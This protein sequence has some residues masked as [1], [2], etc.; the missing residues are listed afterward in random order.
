VTDGAEAYPEESLNPY[1][2]IMKRFVLLTLSC[3]VFLS[4]ISAQDGPDGSDVLLNPGKGYITI[5][6]FTGGF[7]LGDTDVP[8]AKGFFGFTTIHGCQLNKSIVVAGG[9][10]VNFYN[11]GTLF[12]LF[13]DLRYRA[14]VSQWSFYIF[15]D[16]GLMFDFSDNSDTRYFINPGIGVSC[17]LSDKV[18]IN[19]G[20][21]LLT[22]YGD[23]RDSFIN[24]KAGV[25][26]KF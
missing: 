18:A 10:G 13:V 8:Y 7:G 23:V 3:I 12:P 20:T 1:N 16:G 2:Q 17:A 11:E 15:V 22:Q 19:L 4:V 26:C 25:V 5:N 9:A 24:L 14:Y 6:E 21:G